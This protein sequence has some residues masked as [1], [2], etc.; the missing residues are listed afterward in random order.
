M[1]M[2]SAKLNLLELFVDHPGRFDLKTVVCML[3]GGVHFG[4][5]YLY[6][7]VGHGSSGWMAYHMEVAMP[8]I[9]KFTKLLTRNDNSYNYCI[10][11][12]SICLGFVACSNLIII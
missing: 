8:S 2:S 10:L 7:G 12:K 6:D 4:P 9:H 11:S 1:G 5:L 3:S